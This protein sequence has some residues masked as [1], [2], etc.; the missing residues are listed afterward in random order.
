M[1]TSVKISAHLTGKSVGSTLYQ[2]MIGSL[3]YHTASRSNIA[4]NVGVYAHFES[5]PKKSHLTSV[6]QIIKYVNDTVI[7]GLWYT[8]DTN[9][10]LA[11]Y[12][13]ADWV[14]NVDY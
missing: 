8:R 5:N 12:S 4:F 13:N 11:G 2:S 7:Y 14:G 9:L 3:L 10:V 1:S 6:K